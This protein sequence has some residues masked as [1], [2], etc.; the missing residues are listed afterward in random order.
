MTIKSFVHS[1]HKRAETPVLLDSGATENFMSLAYARWL[2]L[3]IKTMSHP[4]P[5]FNV[6]GTPNKMG[7]LEHYTDLRVRTGSTHSR[8]RFFLTDLGNHQVIFGYPWFARNQNACV[9][10]TL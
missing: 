1:S 10:V 2:R 9:Q 5:V 3:P 6:D 8:M 4:R 7:N